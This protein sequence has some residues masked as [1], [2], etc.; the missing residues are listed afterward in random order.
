MSEKLSDE[1]RVEATALDLGYMHEWSDRIAALEAEIERLVKSVLDYG[2]H[3]DDCK[4]GRGSTPEGCD[5]GW[6]GQIDAALSATEKE[7]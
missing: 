4:G 2:T 5:C 7:K 3:L 1:V 6:A